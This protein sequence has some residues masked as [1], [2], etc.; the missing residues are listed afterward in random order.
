[1]A[2]LLLL[3]AALFIALM[4]G[5]VVEFG[6]NGRIIA[7]ARH[8]TSRHFSQYFILTLPLFGRFGRFMTTVAPKWLQS[9]RLR[10]LALNICQQHCAIVSVRVAFTAGAKYALVLV[11]QRLG[12][13]QSLAVVSRTRFAYKCRSRAFMRH[14]VRRAT[15]NLP[16][17]IPAHN[18]DE[19][20]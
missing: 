17:H 18:G 5:G 9:N 8:Y 20:G 2:L 7:S 14:R 13:S 12:P 6:L 16:R 4:G 3:C 11:E 15:R 10:V 1:M 19:D